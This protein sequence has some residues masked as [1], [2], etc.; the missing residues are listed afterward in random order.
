[1]NTLEYGFCGDEAFLDSL[2]LWKTPSAD[3]GDDRGDT[4]VDFSQW[5]QAWTE[6]RGS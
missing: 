2:H 1:M 6:I 5:T 4:C 3:C